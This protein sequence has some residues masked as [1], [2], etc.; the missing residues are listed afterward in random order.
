MHTGVSLE[1]WNI[2]KFDRTIK[3]A[4]E[5]DQIFV[6]QLLSD[7]ASE[8][9]SMYSLALKSERRIKNDRQ[10]QTTSEDQ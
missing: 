9:Y 1:H 5:V 10:R 3:H 8:I 4:V 7:G 2:D 6:L